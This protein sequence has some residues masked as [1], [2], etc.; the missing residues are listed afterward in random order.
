MLLTLTRP[1]HLRKEQGCLTGVPQRKTFRKARP[2]FR[3]A[4]HSAVKG[5]SRVPCPDVCLVSRVPCVVSRIFSLVSR[6]SSLSRMVSHV[7]SYP[8]SVSQPVPPVSCLVSCLARASRVL[9]LLS[10]AVSPF[11]AS[12]VLCLVFYVSYV[13]SS[14]AT[15]RQAQ[16]RVELCCVAPR[17]GAS[18]R[19]TSCCVAWYRN[20]SHHIMS[21]HGLPWAREGS[22]LQT[23]ENRQGR[24][25]TVA[26]RVRFLPTFVFV[27]FQKF[28]I[29]F[30]RKYSDSPV[31]KIC[32][33]FCAVGSKVLSTGASLQKSIPGSSKIFWKF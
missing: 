1:T 18:H 26:V 8:V 28:S 9:R 15:S 10:R 5:A 20:V 21:R 12:R 6:V 11:L 24:G 7:S 14:Y 19:V 31:P 23:V 22:N 30:G 29:N 13:L 27:C 2:L 32:R 25:K 33:K 17:R 4:V 16:F 3:L